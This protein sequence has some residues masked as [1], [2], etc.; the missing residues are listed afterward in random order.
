MPYVLVT[1][2]SS[3]PVTLAEAKAHL[4]VDISDDDTLINA[5]I[6]AARQHAETITQ[7]QLVTAQWKLVLDAFPGAG[8]FGIPAGKPFSLPGHAIL[9]NK[10]PVQSVESIKYLDMG[11]VQQTMSAADYVVDTSS[12][13]ARITPKFGRIWPIALPQIGSIEVAFTAG[14]GAP[15]NAT[16]PVWSPVQVPEGIKRWMLMRV[17]SLYQHR[18]EL[19]VMPIGKIDPLPFVDGLL[20][21][22]RVVIY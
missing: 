15:N 20:D 19:G 18:E 22:Y 7:R 14:Y 3:E 2:P 1:Q 16:P 8:L 9:L 21:P 4:R 5:L 11:G 12:E 17:G 10:S 6:M 13:P